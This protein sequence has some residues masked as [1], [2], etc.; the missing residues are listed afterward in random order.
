MG[1]GE[2][3]RGGLFA[4]DLLADAAVRPGDWPALGDADLDDLEASFRAVF[5]RFPVS[6]SP[7][8]EPDRR[9]SHLA[10]PPPPRVD[11]EPPGSRTSPPTAARTSPTGLLFADQ[12][13]KDRAND[14]AEGVAALRARRRRR[15]VEALAPSPS[16]AAPA[17][18]RRGSRPRPRC[19]GTCGAWT[20]SRPGTSAGASS[21]TGRAGGSTT[22]AP[23]PSPSSSSRSTSEW[24]STSPAT[25]TASSPSPAPTG[26]ARSSG[27]SSSSAGKPSSRTRPMRARS[28]SGRST[29]GRFHQERVAGNLSDLVFNRVFPDLARAIAAAAPDA[30]L[31]EVRDA[32]LVVLYRLLFI[33][34]AEDRDLLPVR[35]ERYD[36]YGLRER[37]RGDVGRRKDGGDTFS[38][39]AS[40]YWLAIDDLSPG[41][42]RR[43]CFH[44]P[45]PL[46]RG[47]LRPPARSASRP[48]P[49][50]RS[51][52]GRRH[53]RALLRGGAGRAGAHINYRDLSVQ[54]LGSI[55]ERLLEHEVVR[56]RD[57]IAVRPN[58][59]A[60]K[61]SGQ[62]L[63]PGRAGGSHPRR[64]GRPAG[65]RPARRLCGAGGR[66]AAEPG[67]PA[68]QG[69]GPGSTTTRPASCWSSRSATRPWG[70]AN[71]WSAS[72]TTWPTG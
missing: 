16:T 42:R 3:F 67:A 56:D 68:A 50:G 17:A 41:N 4:G 15:R 38:E 13:A 45:A 64:G 71:F 32:A 8:E 9:R 39:T 10:G 40:R 31:A 43:R 44:R 5:A 63:H 2:V 23:A 36:D 25:T 22:R 1:I 52:H 7:N 65:A 24:P 30:P 37:V 14:L 35:D 69:P 51:G 21:R 61:G 18:T 57:G 60:R 62:L 19:S 6:Q 54:Q 34:Y 53:R 27:S 46:R 58:V 12:A 29:E 49:A 11:G 59:F 26:A 33:L 28:T 48:G 72:W 20:T 66:A 47:A 70:R 55:Y